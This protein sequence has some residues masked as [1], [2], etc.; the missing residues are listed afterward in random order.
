MDVWIWVLFVS[1]RYLVDH[2]IDLFILIGCIIA[3]IS[4]WDFADEDEA[5]NNLLSPHN[6]WEAAKVP[7]GQSDH[8]SVIDLRKLLIS[9]LLKIR[10]FYLMFRKYKMWLLVI[11]V[12]VCQLVGDIESNKLLENVTARRKNKGKKNPHHWGSS[13]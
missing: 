1:S 5:L 7:S 2:N 4:M 9:I 12:S 11:T 6:A 10:N 13:F 3:L 8:C